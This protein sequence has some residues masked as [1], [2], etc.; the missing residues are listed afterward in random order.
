MMYHSSTL[1][2]DSVV[3]KKNTLFFWVE[4]VKVQPFQESFFLNMHPRPI[5]CHVVCEGRITFFRICIIY[6]NTN[7]ED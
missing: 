3:E 6:L 1:L 7:L 5:K 4:A 2:A